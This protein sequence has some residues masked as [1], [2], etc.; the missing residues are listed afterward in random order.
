MANKVKD[1]TGQKFG[2]LTAVSF[3]HIKNHEAMW[4]CVCDCGKKTVTSGPSMRKGETRSCGCLILETR[5]KVHGMW[6]AR[7]YKIWIGMKSRCYCPTYT[8]YRYYGGRGI[9][10]CPEWKDD[11]AQFYK[12]VGEPPTPKHS[13][14]RINN[15]GNYEPGNVRWA[16]KEEQMNNRRNNRFL[17]HNGETK[18]LKEWSLKLKIDD[19]TLFWRLDHGWSV[20]KTLTTRPLTE[21]K[22]KLIKS[23][24]K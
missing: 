1:I 16:T 18:T 21:I 11:F 3:S 2:K 12:D 17:T 13:M 23:I 24:N 14:D 6:Q 7:M 10:V 9:T 4:H 20:E 19:S 8:N 5:F 15:D 22:S